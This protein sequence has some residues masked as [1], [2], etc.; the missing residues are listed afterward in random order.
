MENTVF[1]FI[2]LLLVVKGVPSVSYSSF[3][4][5]RIE[6]C[7][8]MASSD[9]KNCVIEDDTIPQWKK[10]LMVDLKTYA[11]TINSS[12]L[13]IKLTCPKA[14]RPQLKKQFTKTNEINQLKINNTTI[15]NHSNFNNNNNNVIVKNQQKFLNNISNI[16][17][18]KLSNSL[19]DDENLP[20]P[21][22]VKNLKQKYLS[23]LEDNNEYIEKRST[24]LENILESTNPF[25]DQPRRK[26]VSMTR[27]EIIK[28]QNTNNYHQPN[29]IIIQTAK[30]IFENND[31][32]IKNNQTN[33]FLYNQNIKP[34]ISPN[35]PKIYPKLNKFNQQK[36]TTK[37]NKPP[38][39]PVKPKLSTEHY[40]RKIPIVKPFSTS[41]L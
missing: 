20:K 7:S 17:E 31:N 21:G 35:K 39:S 12:G 29:S 14:L 16:D 36:L 9:M 23:L 4:S 15:S 8:T 19:I 13:S 33:P 28:E 38:V 5:Y 24:S 3:R 2:V 26:S 37:Q 10:E 1:R 6:L 27:L 34:P 40:F 32:N 22:L 41:P 25:S 30:Q 11:K 18:N